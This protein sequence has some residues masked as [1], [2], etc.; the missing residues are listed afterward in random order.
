MYAVI[1]SGGKQ[2]RLAPGQRVKL[3]TLPVEVGQTISFDK[4]LLIA[5]ENG[6]QVGAPYLP[7]ITVKAEV[8]SQGRGP[9]VLIFKL[10]RRKTYRRKQGHRQNYTEVRIQEIVA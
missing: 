7:K 2:Y 9:K 4:V 3:E 8:L 5:N 6:L 1:E 10:R